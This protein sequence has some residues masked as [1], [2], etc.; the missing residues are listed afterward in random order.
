MEF[1]CTSLPYRTD[2]LL[3]H[4]LFVLNAPRPEFSTPHIFRSS[5]PLCSM[6]N[7]VKFNAFGNEF[8]TT[9]YCCAFATWRHCSSCNRLPRFLPAFSPFPPLCL[10]VFLLC[11]N[12]KKVETTNPRR[13]HTH[14]NTK[15][16]NC[17]NK[18]TKGK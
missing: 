17:V 2:F 8:V 9:F 14:M 1:N 6:Q 7:C 13:R 18:A 11:H 15:A 4:V 3:L 16:Q 10:A 12:K 5:R